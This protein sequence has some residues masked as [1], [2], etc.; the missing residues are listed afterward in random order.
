MSAALAGEWRPGRLHQTPLAQVD[1][2][3]YTGMGTADDLAGNMMAAGVGD[4]DIIAQMADSG[5]LQKAIDA[6]EHLPSFVRKYLNRPRSEW[7]Y[8]NAD[9]GTAHDMGLGIGRLPR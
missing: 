3:G 4:P 6:G 7:P 2:A 5:V 8:Q 9:V 1:V